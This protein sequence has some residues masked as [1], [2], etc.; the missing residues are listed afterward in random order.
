MSSEKPRDQKSLFFRGI[1]KLIDWPLYGTSSQK[2]NMRNVAIV[3][4]L[5]WSKTWFAFVDLRCQVKIS[6]YEAAAWRPRQRDVVGDGLGSRMMPCLHMIVAVR[7][8]FIWLLAAQR[9]PLHVILNSFI[10]IFVFFEVVLNRAH[11]S[12]P[13]WRSWQTQ[14]AA[15]LGR[16]RLSETDSSARRRRQPAHAWWVECY[17]S[18]GKVEWCLAMTEMLHFL[19]FKIHLVC[20]CC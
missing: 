12:W 10:F 7:W 8:G 13:Q 17:V 11:Y 20:N 9:T 5:N 4:S 14:R 2:D 6:R 3:R 18:S 15:T 1:W 19:R 16:R